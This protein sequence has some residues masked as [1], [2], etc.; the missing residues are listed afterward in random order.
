MPT[1]RQLKNNTVPLKVNAGGDLIVEVEYRP[2][3]M[4]ADE[5]EHYEE[6]VDENKFNEALFDFI[7]KVVA[8]WD[9]LQD[10]PEEEPELIMPPVPLDV[11]TLR[12]TVP[13]PFLR[14]V[15]VA[16]MQDL[17]PNA[18]SESQYVGSS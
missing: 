12:Q 7:P 17:Y 11:D 2:T 1:L 10:P 9:L 5:Q 8:R 13:L 4:S 18:R 16:I 6:L 3:S 14:K 15:L